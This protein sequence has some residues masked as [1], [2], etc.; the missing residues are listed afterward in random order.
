MHGI[1]LFNVSVTGNS[2]S[3][4][5]FLK[6]LLGMKHTSFGYVVEQV[7]LPVQVYTFWK[8]VRLVLVKSQLIA[9]MRTAFGDSL[10]SYPKARKWQTLR[11]LK[12]EIWAF[13]FDL[14]ADI[15]FVPVRS[16]LIGIALS[17][18]LFSLQA[19]KLER[20]CNVFIARWVVERDL[21]CSRP[22]NGSNR[23]STYHLLFKMVFASYL[24]SSH[25]TTADI[26]GITDI[27][28]AKKF[29]IQFISLR[30]AFLAY[31][32]IAS[33]LGKWWWQK[34]VKKSCVLPAILK[35]S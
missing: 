28:K 20:Y 16:M 31:Y 7:Q 2:C 17:A 6:H 8:A 14:V 21:L 35:N 25:S 9:F 32:D 10:N 26:L 1:G 11:V 15:E 4:S 19:G 24:F 33:A 22:K 29:F 13:G 18:S 12:T 5:L 23:L 3:L 34:A 30:F 27:D